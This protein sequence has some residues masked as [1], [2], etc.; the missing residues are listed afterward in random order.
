MLLKRGE[1]AL[2]YVDD[3]LHGVLTEADAAEV[4]AHCQQCPIC[5]VALG[6][7]E[8]RYEALSTVPPAEPSERLIAQTLHRLKR[9]SIKR[10]WT[11]GRVM[12]WL[13]VAL[14]AC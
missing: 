7:A 1:H 6:E 4:R 10:E 8:K 13:G 11:K 5:Q 12:T 14:A 3:L 2:E 9:R